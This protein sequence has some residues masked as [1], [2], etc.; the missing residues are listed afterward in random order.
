MNRYTA[1]SKIP[2]SR[3]PITRHLSSPLV[4]SVDWSCSLDSQNLYNPTSSPNVDDESFGNGATSDQMHNQGVDI[5]YTLSSTYSPPKNIG[6]MNSSGYNGSMMPPVHEENDYNLQDYD[7]SAGYKANRSKSLAFINNFQGVSYG[8]QVSLQEMDSNARLMES[9]VNSAVDDEQKPVFSI[10]TSTNM[11]L[12]TTLSDSFDM[13]AVGGSIGLAQTQMSSGPQQQSQIPERPT[14]GR[15]NSFAFPSE[16]RSLFDNTLR[17]GYNA[18]PGSFGQYDGNEPQRRDTLSE[19]NVG[20]EITT[21]AADT[22]PQTFLSLQIRSPLDISLAMGGYRSPDDNIMT[23]SSQ[24]SQT[25]FVDNSRSEHIHLQSVLP[26][27]RRHSMA[28]LPIHTSSIKWTPSTQNP[29]SLAMTDN[30]GGGANSI[31]NGSFVSQPATVHNPNMYTNRSMSHLYTNAGQVAATH[32]SHEMLTINTSKYPGS[33]LSP[34]TMTPD[35]AHSQQPK[36][37]LPIPGLSYAY[38]ASL[39]SRRLSQPTVYQKPP[40]NP[41]PAIIPKTPQRTHSYHNSANSEMGKGML[42]STLPPETRIF[43]VKFKGNRRDL[44]YYSNVTHVQNASSKSA[45]TE[46]PQS[47]VFIPTFSP[48]TPVI[49][50]ADR[51]ED[52]GYILSDCKTREDVLAFQAQKA[53]EE[54]LSVSVADTLHTLLTPDSTTIPS[55]SDPISES[56]YRGPDCSPNRSRKSA[57]G[58]SDGQPQKVKDVYIKHIFRLAQNSDVDM[59][60]MKL[61]DENMALKNCQEKVKILGLPMK[62]VDAEYQWDRRKLTFYFI[63]EKRIDFR[64]LVRDLFKTYK[65]RIWMC[66][67][68]TDI[69]TCE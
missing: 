5:R 23:N 21:P 28:T 42:L 59:M 50:E 16:R 14:W 57:T 37:N 26:I 36:P 11:P 54:Q 19:L 15:S 39:M 20:S 67:V 33:A 24:A 40:T 6:N 45:S 35:T 49:V 58:G 69:S 52:L 13:T 1:P 32:V 62:V 31:G 47:S 8:E 64:E 38:Q 68:N 55:N 48:H 3:I 10:H 27:H 53:S 46:R 61:K 17:K 44:Y 41:S 18:I 12:P 65:T 2:I 4:E 9:V 63:A 30:Q 22:A 56:G 25:Q 34:I 7:L 51:G 43:I 29:Q 60:E 66:A